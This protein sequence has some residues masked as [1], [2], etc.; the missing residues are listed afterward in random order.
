[1]TFGWA[2]RGLWVGF[3]V[4]YVDPVFSL[5]YFAWIDCKGKIFEDPHFD[6][7][8]ICKSSPL[9]PTTPLCS[10]YAS[11]SPKFD[12]RILIAN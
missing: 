4:S 7:F 3:E 2:L 6:T 5:C 12:I 9:P 11:Q 1:M 10:G 8:Q